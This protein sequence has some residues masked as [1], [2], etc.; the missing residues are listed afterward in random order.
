[1]AKRPAVFLSYSRED[2]KLAN[3]LEKELKEFKLEIW[4][5][6]RS[7]VAGQRWIDSIEKA[8][9]Q[10]RAVVVLITE[11]SA[12]S[13][14][15]TYEYAFA[16]GA[17]VPVIAVAASGGRPPIALRQFQMVQYSTA[18][19]AAAKI[20]EGIQEQSRSR[21]LDRGLTPQL[22]AKFQEENGEIVSLPSTPK[23]SFGI[24]LW[25]EHAPK[26]TRKVAFEILDR[27]FD[28]RKWTINVRNKKS[29]VREFL[30]DEEMNSWGDVEIWIRGIGTGP[31]SWSMKSRLYEALIRYYSNHQTTAEIRSALK[32]IRK[33]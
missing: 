7:V 8:I 31:G 6:V 3:A 1:M 27:G 32:Q 30:T 5:D 16:S 10:A 23:P 21:A 15:V 11:T 33:S 22:M 13:D 24:D 14:W 4:R 26:K 19:A 9:R 12:K 2:D 18:A 28:N 29:D 17:G 20:N 25:V